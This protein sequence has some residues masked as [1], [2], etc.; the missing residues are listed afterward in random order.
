MVSNSEPM[1]KKNA[2]IAEAEGRQSYFIHALSKEE[3]LEYSIICGEE[4]EYSVVFAYRGEA[5]TAILLNSQLVTGHIRL[6]SAEFTEA[7]IARIH[8][9]K[10]EH[11]LG[12]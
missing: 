2:D 3:W 9:T 5:E 12:I 4:D 8:I 7:A 1:L 10:G 11:V 6:E